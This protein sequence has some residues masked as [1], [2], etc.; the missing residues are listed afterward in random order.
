[1]KLWLFSPGSISR[2]WKIVHFPLL[3]L[4]TFLTKDSR[5][6]L[7]CFLRITLPFFQVISPHLDMRQSSLKVALNEPYLHH[8]A[9]VC[10]WTEKLEVRYHWFSG[11]RTSG[12]SPNHEGVDK[13]ILKS[14]YLRLASLKTE[15]RLLV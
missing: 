4:S 11:I 14:L 9:Y 8:F 12:Y 6:R 15:Q 13:T 7:I 5:C 3:L 1:M 10:D 2:S